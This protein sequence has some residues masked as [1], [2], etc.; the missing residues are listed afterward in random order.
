MDHFVDFSSENVVKVHTTQLDDFEKIALNNTKHRYRW[1]N[2]SS[3]NDMLQDMFL[4]RT[5]GDYTRPDKHINMPESH[6]IIKGREAIIL[7]SD[8]GEITDAFVLDRDNGYLSYRINTD[9][10]HMTI[11][12]T[13]VAVDYEVKLG[14]FSVDS[15]IYPEWAPHENEVEKAK[16]FLH[17]IEEKIK[18]LGIL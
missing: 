11:P 4:L 2:H 12:L 10:Y 15:N 9:I 1:C 6:T 5:R 16:H 7:F 17:D 14:P 18:K 3:P 13:E 8:K